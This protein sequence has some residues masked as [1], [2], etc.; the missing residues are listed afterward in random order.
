MTRV[1]APSRLHFGL[2]HVPADPTSPGHHFGGCGLMIDRP[3]VAVWVEPSD[4]WHGEGPSAARAVE[5]AQRVTTTPHRVTVERCPPEHVGLGVGTSL[6]LAVAKAMR[7]DLSAT[8]LAPLI[9]RG[10]RSGVGLY[11][12][13][14]GGFV[15]DGGKAAGSALPELV[16]RHEFPADW[17]VAL[18]TP[19]QPSR[20]SGKKEQAVFSRPRV[21]EEAS[22]SAERMRHLLS[23]E[24]LPAL[25]ARDFARF[26]EAVY[27]YNR[28]AGLPFAADQGGVY[29]GEIVTSLVEAIRELGVVG[30]G[31]S[32]WGPA[33]FALAPDIDRAESIADVIWD[34][35]AGRTTAAVVPAST[36]GAVVEGGG[37]G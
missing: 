35:F 17:R 3:G 6:G 32:S 20:W 1:V 21:R 15:V 31:Q 14:L 29:A 10:E 34:R 22:R 16:S 13:E 9:G 37:N 11:G 27:E 5:F 26:S 2:L 33:V 30:V 12:F 28:A 25:T 19:D 24:L 23:D 7:P 4:D 18:I 8:Q 36:R